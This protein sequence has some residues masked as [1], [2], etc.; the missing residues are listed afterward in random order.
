[1]ADISII[2]PC[3]NV[4]KWIDRC[5]ESI[6][7]QTIDFECIEIICVD[8]KST[9]GTMDKLRVWEEKYPENIIIACLP[10]HARQGMARNFGFQYASSEWIAF[11]DA[12]DWIEPDYLEL[13]YDKAKTGLYDVVCCKFG[14]DAG[15]ELAYFH[16]RDE[17]RYSEIA[18]ET[19]EDRKNLILN[20][21]LEYG[22]PG[23]LINAGFMDH[24]IIFFPTKIAYEDTVWGSLLHLYVN[25]ACI[26]EN[27]LY[28]YFVNEKSTVLDK[29][30]NHHLDILT[31]QTIAWREYNN[32]GF[33]DKFRE[34]LEIEHIYSGFLAAM[35]VIVLRYDE[36]DYNV[37][38]LLRE[39]ML[40]RIGGFDD[41]KYVKEG[42]VSEF[43]MLILKALDT[44]L[45]QE[46]FLQLAD[47]IKRIGI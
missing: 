42:R 5:L 27:E 32:R 11:I 19:D 18:I 41:N 16:D 3:Y 21:V 9:D 6:I 15:R 17:I 24:N 34:E 46:Q 12:D 13:M 47:S 28:H 45:T 30:S 37:Y 29:N 25:H 38:L 22:A 33:M 43:H 23:K 7:R 44:L 10:F 36:P 4:E 31:A 20:P 2:I 14:R 40:D 1:M 39:I 26:I 8:D 35:K